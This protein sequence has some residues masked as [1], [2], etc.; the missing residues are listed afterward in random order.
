MTVPSSHSEDAFNLSIYRYSLQAITRDKII[1]DDDDDDSDDHD[2]IIRLV[3]L[4][5]YVTA[6]KKSL[7]D[8][9]LYIFSFFPKNFR[10]KTRFYLSV[11]T[12]VKALK[13]QV[14]FKHI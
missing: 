10:S 4:S 7:E 13:T 5:I 1:C 9:I 8:T 3:L 14:F 2:W 12:A 6:S 11:R